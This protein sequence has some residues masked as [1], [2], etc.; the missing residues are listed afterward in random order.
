MKRDR[1]EDAESNSHN[2]AK[3]IKQDKKV[4][5]KFKGNKKQYGFD[6]DIVE[7]V[8]DAVDLIRKGKES[9]VLKSADKVVEVLTEIN[10]SAILTLLRR[11]MIKI[12]R[13]GRGGGWVVDGW[14]MGGG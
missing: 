9:K 4:E 14:W 11:C 8:K 6:S 12:F 5:F 3:R 10:L 2:V 7:R 1:V 13:G